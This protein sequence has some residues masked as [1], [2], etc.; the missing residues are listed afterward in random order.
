MTRES[1]QLKQRLE[2]RKQLMEKIHEIHSAENLTVI[3]TSIK[4]S[5][6]ELFGAERITIYLADH[7]R[8]RLVS[9]IKSGTEIREI[10]VSI[11]GSSL[12]GYC[13]ESGLPLSVRNAYDTHELKMISSTLRF[14][15]SWDKKTGF[16]T[17]Q[18]LCVPLKFQQ[19][20]LGVMQ[21]INKQGQLRFSDSDLEY[22]L[23]LAGSLAI[24]VFNIQRI[25]RSERLARQRGRY[26]YLIER[27]LVDE[28]VLER[29]ASQ[30][31]E[32]RGN[33]DRAVL[34]HCGVSREDM[35][36]SLSLY[37]GAEFILYDPEMPPPD[38]ALL[39]R[40]KPER[41]LS[42]LW[43]PYRCEQ[44]I[45]Y[46]IT[47]DPADLSRLDMIRFVYPEFKKI[48]LSGAFADD[49]TK[50]INLFYHAATGSSSKSVSELIRHDDGQIP[51]SDKQS[52][53]P[54]V[55]EQDSVLVQ[56]VNKIIA[57]GI[58]N[59]VSDIHIEPHPGFEDVLVRMRRDGS[60]FVYQKIPGRY[61]HAL[62]SRIKIMAGLDISERRKPQDGKID[63]KQFGPLDVELRVATIPTVG[64]ME[65][66]VMRV[67]ASGK[68][69]PFDQ[70][71]LSPRNGARLER[72]ITVPH[73]LVLV[74][75]PTGSG[76]TTTL[77]SL[78]ACINTP[79]R[80]IWTAEDPV[81]ITQ[82]GLR[83]VQVQPRIGLT[84][85]TTLRS[86]LRADPDVIMVGEMRDRETAGIAIEASL[87]GHLV[88]STLHT[89]SAAESITR[90]LE[91]D[92]DPFSFSDAM[93]GILA[94][95]LTRRICSDCAVKYQP[96]PVELQELIA[97]YGN[98]AFEKLGVEG[99]GIRLTRGA[100]CPRCGGTGFRGRIAIHELLTGSDLLRET[101]RKGAPMER[102]RSVAI[103]EGMT[104]LKQDGIEK[105]LAGLT[106]IGE[107]RKVCV[108]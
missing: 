57:D 21:I 106:G 3:L 31:Q 54:G 37:Y 32:D 35:A 12:A 49:I 107:V 83:Q 96:S 20:L 77:H 1:E 44:E 102:I 89:N 93:V 69:L 56:M 72:C 45:L 24:S 80:K 65:D 25:A 64:R 62:V 48:V 43:T 71:D 58:R 76:K 75:G 81:E 91:M 99:S 38:N 22:A 100:G 105:C 84:F 95:R 68:P 5:I 42:E 39:R 27:N 10:S 79:D 104:T 47:E 46:V 52:G 74:T 51:E 8:K 33:L 67:L 7:G 59:K 73:G 60:C 70:L 19:T 36:K 50:C 55:S 15:N 6:I 61:K 97:E 66:V 29:L 40:I 41:L 14:D 53:D 87:T 16:V 92:L 26:G 4:D 86:F 2:S 88:F 90:L 101:I 78:L 11:N 98:E 85:A 17:R 18:V 9:R 13:A 30:V 94:Q 108:R 82:R 103:E 34:E 63:F 28:A 23:E